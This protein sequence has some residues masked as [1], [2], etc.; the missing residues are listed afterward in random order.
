MFDF[1]PIVNGDGSSVPVPTYGENDLF[2]FGSS[3]G[4]SATGGVQSRV[5]LQALG[6]T[7]PVALVQN[8]RAGDGP[9]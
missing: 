9:H 4:R 2:A 6:W 7:F 5:I 3:S 1:L 8:D